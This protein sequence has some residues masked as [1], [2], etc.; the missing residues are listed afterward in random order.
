MRALHGPAPHTAQFSP[1]FNLPTDYTMLS[2]RLLALLLLSAL[3]LAGATGRGLL[4]GEVGQSVTVQGELAGEPARAEAVQR[5][6]AAVLGA[7]PAPLLSKGS[8]PCRT[9]G[10]V[11]VITADF[12]ASPP[13]R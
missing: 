1:P 4:Q 2:Q 3:A 13:Q 5:A 7:S 12:L 10:T 11:Q 6:R 9:A 8:R